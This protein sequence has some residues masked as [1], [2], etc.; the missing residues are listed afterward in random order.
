MSWQFDSLPGQLDDCQLHFSMPTLILLTVEW[1]NFSHLVNVCEDWLRVT[2]MSNNKQQEFAARRCRCKW[3]CSVT[4]TWSSSIRWGK[5]GKRA[6][7]VNIEVLQTRD[8][9]ENP[10]L[11]RDE[12]ET[13]H[14]RGME[15]TLWNEERMWLS[16]P[17]YLEGKWPSSTE[18]F[19]A[20]QNG[21]VY[22]LWFLFNWFGQMSKKRY[23]WHLRGLFCRTMQP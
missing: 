6:K 22:S 5:P 17:W 4:A 1:D 2:R 14:V 23:L 13:R 8:L 18:W 21:A 7:S 20:Q 3:S 15:S 10:A 11:W 19:Q 9:H 12:R 16:L